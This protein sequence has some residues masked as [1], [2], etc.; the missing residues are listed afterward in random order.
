MDAI[1]TK[2]E[3]TDRVTALT[4]VAKGAADEV[5]LTRIFQVL[6]RSEGEIQVQYKREGNMRCCVWKPA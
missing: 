5:L 4:L 6:D 1:V 2:E 3:A